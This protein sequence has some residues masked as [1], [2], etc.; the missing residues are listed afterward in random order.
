MVDRRRTWGE[1]R[2]YYQ[3][4]RELKRMPAAWTS[5]AT[6]DPF[7]SLS[8]GRALFRVEDLLELSTLIERQREVQ[9]PPRRRAK[10]R[11]LRK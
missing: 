10:P 9:R 8:A 4:G 1:D 7:V 5:A 3:E 11:V 2:V 6:P